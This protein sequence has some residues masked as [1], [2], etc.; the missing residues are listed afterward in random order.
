MLPP[1]PPAKSPAWRKRR[2]PLARRL[3]PG[4]GG[5]AAAA[6]GF[7]F[8]W[9]KSDWASQWH[10]SP[11]T[12]DGL[13]YSCAEQWMMAEKARL[14]GDAKLRRAILATQDP[15]KQ[16]KLGRRVR[17]FDATYWEEHRE[18]IVYHG[19]LHKFRQNPEL[20]EALEGTGP[21]VLAEASPSDRIWGIGLSSADPRA[22]NTKE[23]K[24]LNLLG[25]ALMRVRETLRRE[26]SPLLPVASAPSPAPDSSQPCVAGAGSV[27]AATEPSTPRHQPGPSVKRRRL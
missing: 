13:R 3:L 2:S 5:A 25:L 9:G 22:T 14:F 11:F 8:F 17:G 23:W 6:G 19:N 1:N 18:E 16:K 20:R 12:V 7:V 24:G 15:Q 4:P 21:Q 27:A 10:K 26:A